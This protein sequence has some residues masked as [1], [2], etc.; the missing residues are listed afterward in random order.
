MKVALFV[1]CYVDQFYPEVAKASLSLLKKMGLS[2]EVPLGQTCC[3]QPMANSGYDQLGKS[4]NHHYIDLFDGY[5]YVVSPSGSCVLHIKEHLKDEQRKNA[6]AHLRE[7][8]YELTEFLTDVMKIEK[9][10]AS[11]PYKVGIHQGC[12]G[13]RGLHLGSMSE[14]MTASFSKPEYLLRM[15]DGISISYP[16]RIDECCGFGGTFC[17]FEEAVSVNMGETRIAEHEANEVDFI[18][19]NDMSCLMHLEGILKRKNSRVKV[20]HI[21]EI[22]NHG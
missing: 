16:E 14:T 20:K 7:R 6:A 12:H 4:C 17:V 18:T 1:P 15:V 2:V 19:S 9:L 11:F 22:L 8:T 21:A 10:N 13:L 3:G 5:D